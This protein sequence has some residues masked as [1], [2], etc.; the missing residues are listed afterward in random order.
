MASL[1]DRKPR[2]KARFLVAL[3]LCSLAWLLAVGLATVGYSRVVSWGQSEVVQQEV[4]YYAYAFAAAGTIAGVAASDAPGRR[5]WAFTSGTMSTVLLAASVPIVR[6]QIFHAT[7]P[8]IPWGQRVWD[9]A[10]EC[11][12]FGFLLGAFV[13]LIVSGLVLASLFVERR[14]KIWQFGLMVAAMVALLGMWA[15]PAAIPHLSDLV[16]L[17]VGVNYR[18]LY[19]E[20]MRGSAT[21]AGTGSLAGAIVTGLI[22]P[23]VWCGCPDRSDRRGRVER[24]HDLARAETNRAA[25]AVAQLGLGVDAQGAVD[26][27]G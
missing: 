18:Y 19:D 9:S 22:A 6:W 21:G 12:G 5:R 1:S 17:R 4:L 15:L 13:G 10:L 23:V 16:I 24:G 26:R 20:A 27:G 2:L 8:S 3:T 14:V 7:A 25:Q 11:I